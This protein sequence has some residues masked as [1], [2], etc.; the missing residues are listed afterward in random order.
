MSHRTRAEIERDEKGAKLAINAG[1][2]SNVC[3]AGVKYVG[4][5]M[6]GSAALLADA[7]HSLADL[8]SDA[9]T[10]FSYRIARQ[11]A[12]PKY[13]YGRGRV[14]SL[15]SLF[16]A[17]SLVLAGGSLGWESLQ[18][19]MEM[20]KTSSLRPIHTVGDVWAV[21][22]STVDS[23][24]GLSPDA[25]GV[26]AGPSDAP[27]AV[28]VRQQPAPP[29]HKAAEFMS[30]PR[31]AFLAVAA[32]IG[33]IAAKEG[34]YQWT[35][36]L[37]KRLRSSVLA[38]NAWHHR[39]DAW[40]SVVAAVGVGGALA[41]MPVLDPLAALVV[42]GMIIQQGGTL[43]LTS[44][45][46]LLDKRLDSDVL[47][48]VE[49]VIKSSRDVTTFRR[50]RA[51]RV[52]PYVL[53]DCE[54]GLKPNL[55]LS[56]AHHIADDVRARVLSARSEVADMLIHT[57]PDEQRGSVFCAD[58]QCTASP[59]ALAASS[60]P[61]GDTIAALTNRSS[62][63][64]PAESSANA[65]GKVTAVHLSGCAAAGGSSSD[66][67]D[68][69]SMQPPLAQSAACVVPSSAGAGSIPLH[70]SPQQAAVL[71]SQVLSHHDDDRAPSI[72]A[73]AA[74]DVRSAF[75]GVAEATFE[76][77]GSSSSTS[78]LTAAQRAAAVAISTEC[79]AYTEIEE[80]RIAS[81][82]V[83]SL[84]APAHATRRKPLHS[85][86]SHSHSHAHGDHQHSHSH[87]AG[88]VAA[89]DHD[90][91]HDDDDDDHD[92]HGHSHGGSPA[93]AHNL[94]EQSISAAAVGRVIAVQQHTSSTSPSEV[95]AAIRKAVAEIPEVGTI[96]HLR[97]HY[98]AGLTRHH[99]EHSGRSANTSSHLQHQQKDLP[100]IG[101]SPN[102]RPRVGL[103]KPTAASTT[104]SQ[105]EHHDDD[106]HDHDDDHDHHH[107]HPR[108]QHTGA[109]V[110]VEME[111]MLGR[112]PVYRVLTLEEAVSVVRKVRRAVEALPAV[113]V[114]DV[115]LEVDP[116]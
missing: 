54:L 5:T 1:A 114:A 60:E 34:L 45:Q 20:A 27:G 28:S 80:K 35:I 18:V 108:Q 26:H 115:H 75:V 43:C 113:A 57:F 85:H 101:R 95:E 93:D 79:P 92:D 22:Q 46:E 82:S 3:L 4:G 100:R 8:A 15:G 36:R 77:H 16:V 48:S 13:P 65:T 2:L 110:R 78:S 89:D 31:M 37:A 105:S 23:L 32:T 52:G 107:H 106:H 14:E 12:D 9:V 6:T 74:P 10:Y 86:S 103:G 7:V 50:L 102:G 69:A 112:C 39:S 30:D 104:S 44:A 53:V 94:E 38:S 58:D 76:E 40:S 98:A 96:T 99:T 68:R 116:T 51:R 56:A 55:T 73:A 41:G 70:P 90:H 72:I 33:S 25:A 64:I 21:A 24:R 109:K 81:A 42:S 47:Q 84:A 83:A 17:G 71:A 62:S 91:H 111:I 29:P 87:G 67:G 63:S 88:A 61:L 59:A 49:R 19:L 66:G 11:P 97:L